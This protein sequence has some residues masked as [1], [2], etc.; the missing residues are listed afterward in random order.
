ML[1]VEGG[2]RTPYTLA[3]GPHQYFST[4]M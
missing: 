4:K 2:V 1:F 3:V